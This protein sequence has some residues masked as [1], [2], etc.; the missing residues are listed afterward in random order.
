M[1]I[2]QAKILGK[3]SLTA[4]PTPEL[5]TAVLLQ[6]VTGFD[7]TKLLVN[8]D[9]ILTEEQEK[10]FT[11][12]LAQRKTGL[13]VAYITG[14][15]EFYGY[16]FF[17]TPDVLIPKPDTEVLIDNALNALAK[18]YAALENSDGTLRRIPTA[19]DMCAG[20]G[21]VGISILKALMEN[22]GL[23]VNDLPKMTF[24]DISIK[25][26]EI[27]KKN[28]ENLLGEGEKYTNPE[29]LNSALCKVRFVQ[30]NL[31]DNLPLKY[32]FIF[33]NPPYVPHTQSRELLKDG[34]SEPLL[35]LDG[36]IDENGDWSGTEDGLS[37]IRRLVPECYE[38]LEKGGLLI[39]ETGEYNAEQTAVLFEECGFKDVRIENDLN[40]MMRNVIGGKY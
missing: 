21:C 26:L 31:F 11:E 38:H 9:Y 16:D 1:T 23:A 32:D 17:V 36:D 27:T 3:E 28:A 4:S 7:K 8:R 5:D 39:M 18:T 10:L 19:L 40:D 30:T 20:S 29:E 2:Q 33:T 34:R 15:K 25:A 14:H 24:A 12:S 13:P 35:A 22:D 37:L 6:H